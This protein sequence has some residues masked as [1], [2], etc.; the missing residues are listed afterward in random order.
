MKLYLLETVVGWIFYNEKGD[1][2]LKELFGL[3]IDKYAEILIKI[4]QKSTSTLEDLTNV[5]K[6]LDNLDTDE[7][8][9][10]NKKTQLVLHQV[11]DK[12][13]TMLLYDPV[14]KQ[15]RAEFLDKLNDINPNLSP[16]DLK[17]Y[18]KLIAEKISKIGVKKNS[19]RNDVHIIFINETLE[20]TI[21]FINLY[22]SRL[23]EWYGVHFPELTDNLIKDIKLYAEIVNRLGVRENLTSQNLQDL[24]KINTEYADEIEKRSAESMGGEIDESQLKVIQN[25][26]TE[27]LRLIE[28]RE[29]NEN[30]LESIL[31]SI[32]PNLY[33]VLGAQLT[34]K[35]IC[36]AGS[37]KILSRMPSSTIQVLGAEKAMFRSNDNTPK[38]GIIYLW[39]NI[40]GAKLWQRGKIS[41]LLAGKISIC[42]KV[43]FFKGNFCGD[44]ILEELEKKIAV[45]EKK[46]PN[47]PNK[48][49]ITEKNDQ[50]E[51]IHRKKDKARMKRKQLSKSKYK[52]GIK[53][54]RRHS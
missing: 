53:G 11:T 42:A 20:D 21:K 13:I 41:R 29:Q 40:R 4:D 45:I 47:P 37:L 14:F 51:F 49:N 33:A 15:L 6:K 22:A 39:P 23:R 46:F 16:I 19:E 12:K 28:F 31:K 54:T 35:L 27:I 9:T 25:L 24:F 18:A 34:G 2:L 38:H 48:K 36:R 44:K 3:D 43:D 5:G 7:I 26:S 52:T 8:F 17:K 30:E 1:I 10:E 32:T 50:M